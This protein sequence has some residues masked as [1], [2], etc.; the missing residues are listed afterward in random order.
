MVL[1]VHLSEG[2]DFDPQD[3]T[4]EQRTQWSDPGHL[5]L[6]LAQIKNVVEIKSMQKA[7][8]IVT[9]TR[10]RVLR[11]CSQGLWQFPMRLASPPPWLP[12]CGAFS[13]G[14]NS[15]API[16]RQRQFLPSCSYSI[17]SR[18]F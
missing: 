9:R 14:K 7:C 8:D 10:L 16:V 6:S 11:S 15:K 12:L 5:A 3:A 4:I 17:L 2:G 18:F 13:P 1:S